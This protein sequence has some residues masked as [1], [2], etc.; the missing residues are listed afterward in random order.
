MLI[1]GER[2]DLEYSLYMGSATRF[3]IE[4]II[5][6]ST[7]IFGLRSN[8]G[9]Q[10]DQNIPK[11]LDYRPFRQLSVDL[12]DL[13]IDT[14]GL[15]RLL[16][17]ANAGQLPKLDNYIFHDTILLLGYRLVHVSPLGGPRPPSRLGNAV[18]LG[19]TAF[20]T[21]FLRKLDRTI[22]D[23]PLLSEL[24]RSLAQEHFDDDQEYQEVLLWLL[25]IGRAS[26]FKEPDDVWLIP[27][28]AQ[29]M[30]ALGLH[31]WEDVS[32]TLAIFPWV[33]ALHDPAGQALW[34]KSS[35]LL[36]IDLP[37]ESLQN[38]PIL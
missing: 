35:S 32:R 4:D 7:A 19:L 8:F 33:N 26:I 10:N 11:V 38:D 27:K 12:Q 24:V 17:D 36:A 9:G 25:F 14:T 31:T 5:S 28:T 13:L 18:H 23:I 1:L 22:P 34:H 30:H 21:T 15:A 29:T 6:G 16:N 2:A 20:V 37:V 3:S